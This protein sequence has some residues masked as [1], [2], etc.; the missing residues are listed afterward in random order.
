[1]AAS[2]VSKGSIVA[3]ENG[4]TNPNLGTLVRLADALGMSVTDLLEPDQAEPVRVVPH[5]GQAPLW[6]GPGESTA[7]LILTVPG[8]T[9]VEFWRWSLGPGVRYESHPHPVGTAETVTVLTGSLTLEL[10]GRAV[11][12]AADATATFIADR[13]HAYRASPDGCAFLMTVHLPHSH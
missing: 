3:L 1:M 6:E 11:D 12:I 7:S 2:G 8:R 10:D 5:A 9:A 4:A 13:A